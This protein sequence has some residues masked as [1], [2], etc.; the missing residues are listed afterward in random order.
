MVVKILN[1]L[2]V[3]LRN[4]R[5]KWGHNTREHHIQA[6][7]DLRSFSQCTNIHIENYCVLVPVKRV[8]ISNF[9][10]RVGS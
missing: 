10:M 3:I 5:W 4:E 9:S 1:H 7:F 8:V 2:M 6:H